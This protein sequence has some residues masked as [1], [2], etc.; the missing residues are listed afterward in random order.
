MSKMNP[1]KRNKGTSLLQFPSDYT[2]ID[3][4]T[5]GLSPNYDS[6]IEISCI[7]YRNNIEVDSFSS[8]VQPPP[9][10]IAQ[11]EQDKLD[12][13]NYHGLIAYVNCFISSFTGITSE[14]LSGAP[15]FEDIADT[16]WNFLQN[17]ILVGHN[18]HFDLNFL[19][20]NLLAHNQS[21]ILDNDFVDTM[22]IAR[23]ALPD[24]E[25]HSLTDLD[26]Y[27]D[28]QIQHHRAECDCQIT[29]IVLQELAKVVTNNAIDLTPPKS[30]KKVD[31]RTLTASQSSFDIGH[32][33]Y[34]KYCVFTGKLERFSRKDAAQIVVNLGGHCE[35][36]VTK[37]TNFLI[38]GDLEYVSNIKEGKS[39]K[40]KKAEQLIL[41]GQDLQIMPERTFYDMINDI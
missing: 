35:N 25:H 18:I 37:K 1:T 32:P 8:L 9:F 31:L 39:N 41:K 2:V 20:D 33:L 17:E 3:I 27:F 22:R 30:Y 13:A 26:D 15:K 10:H 23:L 38:V 21:Y 16:L 12:N 34:N 11:S 40:L 36:A 7:K 19:Y 29:N 4:E 28:I 14:M 24:L 5:T 6:I